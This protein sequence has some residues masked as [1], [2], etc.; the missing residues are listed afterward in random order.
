[1]L[2]VLGEANHPALDCGR[3]GGV[4]GPG[5]IGLEKLTDR[6]LSPRSSSGNFGK[7]LSL[8][9]RPFPT[10]LVLSTLAFLPPRGGGEEMRIGGSTLEDLDC[11]SLEEGI[12]GT[13][14]ASC[15][16]GTAPFVDARAGE[17]DLNVRSVIDPELSCLTRPRPMP[18]LPPP[19]ML[20]LPIEDCD[21]RLTM[22]FVCILPTSSGETV[23]ER[24]AAAA[25][26]EDSD[27]LEGELLRKAE[28]AA[29]A[30]EE[31]GALFGGYQG[32]TCQR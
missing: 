3:I 25:A 5:D 27:A 8:L 19:M 20:P 10:K 22:R 12:D 13:G 24:N 31:L 26:A 28:L 15:A 9:P 16:A 14:G 29:I 32:R 21:P 30:A 23:C 1:M 4:V 18:P 17:G 7:L 6:L 2:L 11:R